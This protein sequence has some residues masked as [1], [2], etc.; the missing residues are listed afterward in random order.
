MQYS[1]EQATHIFDPRDVFAVLCRLLTS[2]LLNSICRQSRLSHVQVSAHSVGD[3]VK[4]L[5]G[6]L[7]GLLITVRDSD[8]VD[9]PI[10][11]CQSGRQEGAGQ[12]CHQIPP[13]DMIANSPT[14][15]VVPSPISSS[16][17]F[18]TSTK[19]LAIWCSTSI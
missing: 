18:E 19:S 3:S 1:N 2:S 7:T 15:P 14:T 5:N 9:T 11:Q 4:L 6:D 8:R 13:G 10:E 16:C 12:N 17:D